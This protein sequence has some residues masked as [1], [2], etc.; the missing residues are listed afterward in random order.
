MSQSSIL[1]VPS[2]QSATLPF[3]EPIARPIRPISPIQALAL[4]CVCAVAMLG[5]TVVAPA[6]GRNPKLLW[7]FFG[8]AVALILWALAL[9][10]IVHRKQRSLTLQI[11]LRKQHYL[12]ACA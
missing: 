10:E 8:A 4:P 7:S 9:F 1:T 11:V 2:S 3:I 5:L 12:Q 6:A